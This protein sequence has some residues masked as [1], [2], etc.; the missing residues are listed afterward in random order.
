MHL[1]FTG[2]ERSEYKNI[3]IPYVSQT[4][5]KKILEILYS[6][7]LKLELLVYVPKRNLR[8][9]NRSEPETEKCVKDVTNFKLLHKRKTLKAITNCKYA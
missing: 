4:I 7:N 2:T 6:S 8:I 5:L 3:N 1:R 9:Q